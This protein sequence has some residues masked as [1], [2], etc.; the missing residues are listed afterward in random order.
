[1][2]F[3]IQECEKGS[4]QSAF[5]GLQN[6]QFKFHDMRDFERMVDMECQRPREQWWMELR[7]IAKLLAQPE[8]TKHNQIT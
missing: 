8:E 3:L 5:L 2:E 7:P 1:L 4:N 6:G